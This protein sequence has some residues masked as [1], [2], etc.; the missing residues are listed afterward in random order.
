MDN[1]LVQ[2]D[3]GLFI[4]TI[5]TFLILFFVLAKYAWRPLLNKLAEREAMIKKSL[6]DA[7]K[8]QQ[9]LEKFNQESEAI[10]ARARSEAQSILTEG[11]QAAEKVKS[12]IIIKAKEQ[13]DQ[14]LKNAE[15]QIHAEQ[16]QAIA[17]IREEVVDLSLAVAEKLIQK[18]LSKQ[19]NQTLIEESLK[20]VRTYEA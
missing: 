7:E 9:E 3:P 19:E 1:P 15:K 11:K 13:A 20:K 14:V 5:V 16:E 2:I 18:N 6:D 4:W 17:R 12:E 8:A 10:I